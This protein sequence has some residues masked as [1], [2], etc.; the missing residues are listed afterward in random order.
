LKP[1][2]K[3]EAVL[4]YLPSHQVKLKLED[5]GFIGI[6]VHMMQGCVRVG[7]IAIKPVVKEKLFHAFFSFI[8]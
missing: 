5:M 2:Y 1:W 6:R 3:A 4:T 7:L 8:P